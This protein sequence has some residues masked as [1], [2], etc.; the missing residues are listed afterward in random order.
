MLGKKNVLLQP[1]IDYLSPNVDV[2]SIIS[3]TQGR[4]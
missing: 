2:S 3:T 4:K 1:G